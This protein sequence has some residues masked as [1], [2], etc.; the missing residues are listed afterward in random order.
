MLIFLAQLFLDLVL[1]FWQ[2]SWHIGNAFCSQQVD[3]LLLSQ[4]TL[5]YIES[6]GSFDCA[7]IRS[8][9]MFTRKAPGHFVPYSI[10]IISCNIKHISIENYVENINLILHT[11]YLLVKSLEYSSSSRTTR[12]M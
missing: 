3:H 4:S 6:K 8:R 11:L 2:Y 10:T 12:K 5:V 9:S 1:P 7:E